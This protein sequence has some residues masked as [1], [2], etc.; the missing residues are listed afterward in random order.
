M[1]ARY[2]ETLKKL[3]QIVALTKLRRP[4]WSIIYG[5]QSSLKLIIERLQLILYYL[6][7]VDNF[8]FI[9]LC[10]EMNWN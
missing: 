4:I 9:C 3:C 6:L 8:N 2:L 10:S 7:L 1:T 5:L